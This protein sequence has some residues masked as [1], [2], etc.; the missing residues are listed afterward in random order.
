M[1][2]E[3]PVLLITPNPAAMSLLSTLF[4]VDADPLGDVPCW[5]TVIHLRITAEDLARCMYGNGDL[6]TIGFLVSPD[7]AEG[8]VF[9]D[10][11]TPRS[12]F[13]D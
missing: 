5:E 11:E 7:G 3:E 9:P 1:A 13:E 4:A 2:D 12:P 8:V 10:P 6:A